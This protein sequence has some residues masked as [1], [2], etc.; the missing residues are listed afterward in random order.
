MSLQPVLLNLPWLFLS[1]V[2][3]PI[4][5]KAYYLLQSALVNGLWVGLNRKLMLLSKLVFKTGRMTKLRSWLN[6]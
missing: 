2:F 5:R 6:A 4:L 1:Q 3:M